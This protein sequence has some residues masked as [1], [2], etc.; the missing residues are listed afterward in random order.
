MILRNRPLL[1]CI[2]VLTTSCKSRPQQLEDPAAANPTTQYEYQVGLGYG[3]LGKAVR[4]TVDGDEVLSLVGSDE[5]EQHAQLLGTKMLVGGVS[6]GKDITVRV[7]VDGARPYE[8]A[9]DLSAG[10][11]IHIYNDP[12]GLRVFNTS[13]L[14]QE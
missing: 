1:L 6:S 12:T 8:Q 3:F 13:F 7:T 14:V 5:I 4:V 10:G 9:I 11:Y 2:L